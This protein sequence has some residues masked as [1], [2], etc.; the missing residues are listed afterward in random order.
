MSD[1]RTVKATIGG[2]GQVTSAT[3]PGLVDIQVNGYAQVDFNAEPARLELS[4]IR[5]AC[6]KMRSRGVVRFLPTFTTDALPNVLERLRRFAQFRRD[7]EVVESMVPGFHMEG[8]FISPQDGPRGAHPLEHCHTPA[9]LRGLVAQLQEACGG[10]LKIFSLAPEL[11]GAMEVI[12]S[13]A[14]QG[15][16]MALAHHAATPDT[17]AQAVSTGARLCTH[18][19]NGAHATLP[20]SDNYIQ[21]QLA[22]DRLWASFIADGHH[23]VFPT[24]KNYLRA[25]QFSR[26]ILTTDAMAAADAPPGRYALG[27][28]SVDVGSSGRVSLSG[29]PYLAGSALTLDMALLNVTRN[30]DVTFAQAWEMASTQPAKLLGLRNLPTIKVKVSEKGFALQE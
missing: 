2:G 8:I 28:T 3:G 17:I 18:L 20:R 15:V 29:T 16:V 26:C 23:I 7:D 27:R 11:P 12:A 6:Q 25:K 13:G 21:H 4:A 9:Q 19:G 10:L 5:Q 22:N 24:L 1:P 14:R 30:C